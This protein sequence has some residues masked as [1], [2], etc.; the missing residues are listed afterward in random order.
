[1]YWIV[2][3]NTV[4]IGQDAAMGAGTQFK[5]VMES[6]YHLINGAKSKSHTSRG[7]YKQI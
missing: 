4:A 1:M 7:N 3:T 2:K 6:G 5:T